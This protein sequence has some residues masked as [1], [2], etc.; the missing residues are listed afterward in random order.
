MASASEPI[1]RQ[2]AR[3][4]WLAR[5]AGLSLV[6]LIIGS[7]AT[8]DAIANGET[9][10]ISIQ[11]MHT[12]ELTTVT[13]RR[14]GRYV[15]EALD[16]LN[17][18]LR[19]WRHDEPTKMD[20]RLFD[21]A[22]E[23]QREAGS[24]GPFHVVSAYRSPATNSMLRRRS[25]GVA[26]HSQHTMGKA[27]DFYLPDVGPSQ[28]RAIGVKLQRGG[29][30]YYP[31]A[32]TPFI[33]LD[34]G[35]VRSWPRMTR[36]QL[37]RLF[38]D[39]RTVHIAADGRPL[40]G[41]ES[42]KAMIIARGGSV[43]GFGSTDFDEGAIMQGSRRSL[44]ASLFGWNEEDESRPAQRGRL[45]ARASQPALSYAPAPQPSSHRDD[46][47]VYAFL[48]NPQG[49]EQP[50]APRSTGR[51]RAGETQAAALARPAD[52]NTE[53]P[54]PAPARAPV[55]APAPEPAPPAPATPRFV[56]APFPTARP[57][58][59]APVQLAFVQ[60][61]STGARLEWNQGTSGQPAPE[62]P[63]LAV[64][65]QRVVLAP[66]PPRRPDGL[67]ALAPAAITSTSTGPLLASSSPV[68][69]VTLLAD[70]PPKL[71][72][73]S[74]PAPPQRP[75]LLTGTIA[76]TE[77][78]P[79]ATVTA[80]A[81]PVP[82]QP[83]QIRA[84][85]QALDTLFAAAALGTLP[86]GS[87]KIMTSRARSQPSQTEPLDTGGQPAAALGFTQRDPNDARSDRFSGPAVRPLPP[88]FTS[89]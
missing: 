30:G 39:G 67:V 65:S 74:H 11:H 88:T 31:T 23:V 76:R 55:A 71:V 77:A 7:R 41:Y 8:Q 66:V 9:R 19:D 5:L 4:A 89:P 68:V 47:G 43:G 10:T 14:D 20:P 2:V 53:A 49:V 15:A 16:K 32:Y 58:G 37:A 44:W 29:V 73:V 70:P 72:S 75:P 45:G 86:A 64:S 42:A 56:Q 34:V 28:I 22:W 83:A 38:P 35:S 60:P 62:T 79:P 78:P 50:A 57:P 17:W 59:L 27:M 84:E 21:I 12:K 36:D 85:R 25:R 40:E 80:A 13:F 51:S 6:A 1:R 48:S 63:T 3:A 33:H 54:R 26:K 69:A 61:G 24:A 81:P 46:A 82:V 87:A 52:G 18:A